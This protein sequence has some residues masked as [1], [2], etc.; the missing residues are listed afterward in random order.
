MYREIRIESE[1]N[2]EGK[3]GKQITFKGITKNKV[4]RTTQLVPINES[5]KRTILIVKW[6]WFAGSNL[7]TGGF[8]LIKW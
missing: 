1:K 2:E 5:K 3:N 6:Y 8:V 7:I 4:A